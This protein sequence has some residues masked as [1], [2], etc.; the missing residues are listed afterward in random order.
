[1]SAI[2][3][4]NPFSLHRTML[5]VSMLMGL[6]AT[7]CATWPGPA[8]EPAAA[9][10]SVEAR[11]LLGRLE[12]TNAKLQSFKGIGRLTVR[13]DGKIQVDERI[14]WIGSAPLRLGV[15][16]FAG[17]VPAVRMASD[18]EWLYYQDGQ[19]PGLPVKKVR[20]SDP[21]FDR[22]LSIPIQASDIIALLRG[23]IPLREHSSARLL[24]LA[25]G[26]GQV[27]LLDRIWGVHQKIFLDE[28]ASEVKQ[29]EVY[30]LSGRL[31]FQVNFPEM[32]LIDG[33]RVPR[34]LVVSNHQTNAV[35]QLVVEKYWADVP[36]TPSMFV[37][38]SPG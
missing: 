18:G 19:E 21:D 36:V 7:G 30:D 4:Q 34:R 11:A 33:Y 13:K 8:Q 26:N 31:L 38:E 29:T 15:V 16:L 14:A 9:G 12:Q 27:L 10:D 17:G 20:A 35:V 5:W 24:P 1:M 2:H 37:L 22:L 25:S 23:R 3:F 28:Q 6:V 32:Q